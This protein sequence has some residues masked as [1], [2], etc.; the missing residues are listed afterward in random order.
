M[1]LK[2]TSIL[3]GEEIKRALMELRRLMPGLAAVADRLGHDLEAGARLM[4][5]M[6]KCT[7]ARERKGLGIKE[8]AK[9]LKVPQYRIKGIEGAGRIGDA[10]ADVLR[11]YVEL[12]G[13]GRWVKRWVAA[14][15]ELAVRIGLATAAPGRTAKETKKTAPAAPK[16]RRRTKPKSDAWAR[17]ASSRSITPSS[18]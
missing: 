8:V 18:K 11:R 12:L 17:W 13:I 9:K 7:E 4:S 15:G 5:L 2:K 1:R 14:N 10:D 3:N 6:A 16:S